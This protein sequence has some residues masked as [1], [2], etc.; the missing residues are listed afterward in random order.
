M[1]GWTQAEYLS[2][3]YT[4]TV[5]TTQIFK[6][7]RIINHD[8]EIDVLTGTTAFIRSCGPVLASVVDE[9][10]RQATKW[11]PQHHSYFK[12]LAILTEEVG[13][14]AKAIL[15]HHANEDATLIRE[16]LV[17]VAAVAVAAIEDIDS[18]YKLTQETQTHAASTL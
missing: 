17:Q 7:T 4:T 13:E 14:V 15:E 10:L 11:G 1:G 16:E 6:E 3:P 2:W 9:R 8:I 5:G 12:W 18:T